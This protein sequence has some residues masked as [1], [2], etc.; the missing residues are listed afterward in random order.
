MGWND[1]GL[2]SIIAS[3]SIIIIINILDNE[4]VGRM[5]TVVDNKKNRMKAKSATYLN[6]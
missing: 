4:E 6:F 5:S 3:I 1:W 2:E